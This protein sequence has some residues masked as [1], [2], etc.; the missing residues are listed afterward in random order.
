MT[1]QPMIMKKLS[2]FFE[3]VAT[4]EEKLMFKR[5]LVNHIAH[6]EGGSQIPQSIQDVYIAVLPDMASL[7]S[8][9]NKV[10]ATNF[11]TGRYKM[12]YS[13]STTLCNAI[14]SK[15]QLKKMVEEALKEAEEEFDDE[16]GEEEQAEPVDEEK[17]VPEPN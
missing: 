16:E 2:K 15:V 11:N 5:A 1:R 14:R 13:Y 12:H 4:E 3:R 9:W 7:D 17:E 6:G 8:K 10:N